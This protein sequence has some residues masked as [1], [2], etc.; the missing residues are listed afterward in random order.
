MTAAK[1]AV[2]ESYLKSGKEDIDAMVKL[3]EEGNNEFIELSP[4]S[5][6]AITAA[7]RKWAESGQ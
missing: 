2:F 4:E 5:L 7:G 3:R 1:L 6:A